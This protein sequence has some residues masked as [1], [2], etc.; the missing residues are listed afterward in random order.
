MSLKHE[1]AFTLNGVQRKVMVE[2]GMSTLA[3]L[4][5]VIGLR[6]ILTVPFFRGGQPF[7]AL[8]VW[9]PEPKPF[10]DKQIALLQT[11]ADQAVIAIE[12]VR[13]FNE[14]QR[15]TQELARSVEQ[16]RSL[17]E[18]GQAVNSTLDLD[19]V[20]LGCFRDI[21]G[22]A[23]VGTGDVFGFRVARGRRRTRPRFRRRLRPEPRCDPSEPR[24]LHGR[25]V[26]R[27]LDAAHRCGAQRLFRC[28]QPAARRHAPRPG[29]D[30]PAGAARHNRG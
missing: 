28:D 27:R 18:V 30:A 21:H 1:I 10:T 13:L 25:R 19:Q 26:G 5:D 4:R 16:L 12:N 15:R 14:L 2:V 3:M 9:R 8:S 29:P 23:P 11:F 6:S 22:R 7:G 20:L 24:P 17:S